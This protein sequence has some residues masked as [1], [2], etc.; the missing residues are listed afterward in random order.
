MLVR[1]RETGETRASHPAEES[2]GRRVD[3][4]GDG[5]ESR[6]DGA[7]RRDER[8]VGR[9]GKDAMVQ[10]RESFCNRELSFYRDSVHYR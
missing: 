8:R 3:E 2:D 7:S 10:V 1:R 6:E 9:F 5:T 4:N